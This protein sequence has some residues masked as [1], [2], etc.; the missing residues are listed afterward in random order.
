[1]NIRNII[2]LKKSNGNK[3]KAAGR[4][5]LQEQGN[6]FI[7]YINRHTVCTDSNFIYLFGGADL[8]QRTCELY[9]FDPSK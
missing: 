9:R 1:M 7:I 4:F 5:S 6:I 8:E 2:C 3:L